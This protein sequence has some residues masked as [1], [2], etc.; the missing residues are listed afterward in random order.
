MEL[1]RV[2]TLRKIGDSR[3][4]I[5]NREECKIFDLKVGDIVKINIE[6]VEVKQNDN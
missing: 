5:F 2:K 1:S 4:I 6:K 3:G